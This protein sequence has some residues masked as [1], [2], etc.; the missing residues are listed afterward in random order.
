[1]KGNYQ[2]SKI[3][4]IEPICDHEDDEVYYG[5]T[6][7]LLCKRMSHHREHYRRYLNG[8]EH[9]ITSYDIFDKYGM[10]NCNIYLIEECP[11]ENIEQ[12]RKKEGEYIKGNGCVN[13]V[14]PGRTPKEWRE[15]NKDII[16]K[17]R[18]QYYEDNKDTVLEKRKEH[19]TVNKEAMRKKNKEYYKANKN[20]I[21][22][23]I[24]L[25]YT[26][27]C[28]ATITTGSR[29]RHERTKKHQEFLEQK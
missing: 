14:I 15:D 19:Y 21:L 2:N 10:E 7:Q 8:K 18:K 1:M 26:C 9:K 23:K 11:C 17:Q 20:A 28:G 27:E 24:K 22:E 4:K 3:Y 13:K 6:T 29:V 5:S 12:L 16:N 25:T